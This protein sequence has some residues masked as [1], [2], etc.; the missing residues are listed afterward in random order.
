MSRRRAL[1]GMAYVSLRP[2]LMRR[3]SCK[4]EKRHATAEGEDHNSPGRLT[5]NVL[6]ID[7]RQ[8]SLRANARRSIAEQTLRFLLVL[9][10]CVLGHHSRKH[11]FV[12]R[13]VGAAEP[14]APLFDWP[15]IE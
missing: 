12:K 3:S 4:A 2:S 14:K 5:T 7:L 6:P 11:L 13:S 1:T 15:K 8:H 9:L 10:A